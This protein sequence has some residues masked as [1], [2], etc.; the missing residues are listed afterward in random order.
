VTAR[1]LLVAALALALAVL[2]A[3]APHGLRLLS[4]PEDLRAFYCAGRTV[5][6]H[7]DPYLAEPLR[8]CEVRTAREAGLSPYPGLALPAP[9][10][11]F[12]LLP[13]AALSPLDFNT[14]STLYALLVMAATGATAILLARALHFPLVAAAFALG[15]GAVAAA[16]NGQIFPFVLLALCASAYALTRGNDLAAA[17]FAALTAVEPH[18]ALAALAG[19]AYARPRTRAPLAL[20][21]TLFGIVALAMGGLH[22]NLEYLL[23]V[24]PAH[25]RSELHG[26]NQ[27]SLTTL[28]AEA[29]VAP[30]LAI[31]AG[32]VQYA[33]MFVLGCEVARRAARA[34]EAP[35]LAVLLPPAFVALGGP[36]IHLTQIAV[37]IPAGIALLAR[38]PRGR[39]LAGSALLLLA[40]PWQDVVENGVLAATAATA[41]VGAVLA[42]AIWGRGR[43]LPVA[44]LA[45]ALVAFAEGELRQAYPPPQVSAT[46]ALAAVSQPERLAEDSWQAYLDA[47]Q[48]HQPLRLDAVRLPA[49]A[50]LLALIVAAVSAARVRPAGMRDPSG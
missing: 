34:L 35:E 40:V 16:L 49:W 23:R 1:R 25:A 33:T 5:L 14:V 18:V 12:A 32:N 9:L 50:G 31:A 19:L 28:L 22:E 15:L 44:T 36:F 38:F 8:S 37:A 30:G 29:G 4:D 20:A 24:L 3:V 46:A 43:A 41:C 45:L 39:T 48:P 26:A 6:A 7:A 17:A 2:V 42:Y 13:F 11:L 10:P 21:L 47:T 27:Y